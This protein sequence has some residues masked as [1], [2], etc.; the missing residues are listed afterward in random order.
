MGLARGT[1]DLLRLAEGARAWKPSHA[2]ALYDQVVYRR[3]NEAAGYGDGDHLQAAVSWLERAQDAVSDGGVCGRYGLGEGWTSS[4][5][6]TTGY[7]VPTFLAL[8]AERGAERFVERARRAV[9]FLLR[10]QNADGSFN[11]GEVHEATGEPAVFNTA[12]ILHGLTEWHAR[13]GDDAVLAAARRAADWMLRVQ[14]DDGAWRRCVYLGVPSSYVAHASCWLADFGRHVAD[15]R[16]LEGAR[17]HLEWVLGLQDPETGWFDRCG[18]TDEDHAQRRSVTHTIAYTLWGVLHT[19]QILDHQA[20]VDAVV[21]AAGGIAR[22]LGLSQSKRLPGVL[23]RDWT[24]RSRYVCLT[25]N[26][27]MALVWNRLFWLT[28]EGRFLNAALDAIDGV[29]SAQLMRNPAPGLRG[30]IP[31]SYPIW[32]EYLRLACPNWAAKFYVDA[33]LAK[34]DTMRRL[35]ER[36]RREAPV[37]G[38]GPLDLPPPGARHSGSRPV[39]VMVTSADSNR[40]PAMLRAWDAW[41]FKPDAVLVQEEPVPPTLQ[42]LARKVRDDG[43][44]ALARRLVRR[45]PAHGRSAASGPGL[46][47]LCAAR[48]IRMVRTGA[49]DGPPAVAA[50]AALHPDVVIQAGA[51]ILRPPLLRAVRSGTLNAHMGLLPWYRG[52]NVAEWALFHRDPVGCTVHLVAEGIDTGDLLCRRVVA[53]DGVRSIAELRARVDDAQIALLGEVVRWVLARGTLPP[54]TPQGPLAG[55]QYFRMHPE[56]GAA[57]ERETASGR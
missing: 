4:Y 20:G 16:Y 30:A 36:P 12:Q 51:G 5:P 57:L 55:L 43:V 29:K 41:S 38:G 2:Q 32:G 33:L 34:R 42:R 49:L 31:G 1:Y 10:C 37:Q 13:T 53:A 50:L 7:I 15:A 39:I 44:A 11:G 27:Q 26:A 9:E 3:R 56:I 19:S 25:G 17:R 8:A 47:T 40:V 24:A 35:G 14:D 48:G 23:D 18:F 52:M 21:R 54:R 28:G 46:A 22:R 45:P 6:E